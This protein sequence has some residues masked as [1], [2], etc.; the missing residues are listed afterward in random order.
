MSSPD[1]LG[2][3]LA[4]LLIDGDAPIGLSPQDVSSLQST[5]LHQRASDIAHGVSEQF[6]QRR[7]EP[8]G[9]RSV[10]TAGEMEEREQA[11]MRI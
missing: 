6:L 2:S 5:V 11:D 9:T 10:Q 8:D 1:R 3:S 7:M 4:T